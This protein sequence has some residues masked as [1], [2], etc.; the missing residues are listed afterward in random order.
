VLSYKGR[1]P[2]LDAGA[3]V[4]FVHPAQAADMGDSTSVHSTLVSIAV[5]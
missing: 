1:W 5:D 4:N 2:R 3:S